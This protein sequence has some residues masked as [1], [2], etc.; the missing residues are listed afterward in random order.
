[1]R[2]VRKAGYRKNPSGH[3]KASV[4]MLIHNPMHAGWDSAYKV[5]FW[6]ET[7]DVQASTTHVFVSDDDNRV[8]LRM[9]RGAVDNFSGLPK[10]LTGLDCFVSL[11]A[12]CEE[13]YHGIVI[14]CERI[15]PFVRVRI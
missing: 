6:D 11:D 15:G 2:I 10:D 5:T 13:C 7:L 8:I 3:M 1:M 14:S 12:D 9:T 4:P